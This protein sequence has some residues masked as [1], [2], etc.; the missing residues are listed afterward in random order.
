MINKFRFLD[1]GSFNIPSTQEL[2]QADSGARI[3]CLMTGERENG[4]SGWVFVAV[5][6]SLYEVFHTR[7]TN[8]EE[9]L[10]EAFGEIIAHGTGLP[11]PAEVVKRMQS[12][13]GFDPHFSERLVEAAKKQQ[14]AL[15]MR[16]DALRIQNIVA[17][18][19]SQGKPTNESF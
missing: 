16:Q 6:P 5:R 7:C 18:L 19:K 13:Y 10:P 3:I 17:T 12:R 14:K 8:G 11:P 15:F 1:N 2:Q 9:L 4:E